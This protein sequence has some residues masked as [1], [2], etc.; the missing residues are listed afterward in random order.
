VKTPNRIYVPL[1]KPFTS[2]DRCNCGHSRAMHTRGT[3]LNTAECRIM[4]C[5]C[6]QFGMDRS[7][8]EAKP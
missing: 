6:K 5:Y 4:V 8:A 1:C 3:Y 7:E 2:K